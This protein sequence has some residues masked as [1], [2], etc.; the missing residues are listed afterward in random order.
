M[1]ESKTILGVLFDK[2][3]SFERLLSQMIAKGWP[4]FEECSMRL[5]VDGFFCSCSHFSDPC[6]NSSGAFVRCPFPNYGPQS[7][8]EM[9]LWRW[10]KGTLGCRYQRELKHHLVVAQCGW[11]LRSSIFSTARLC[12]VSPRNAIVRQTEPIPQEVY[13]FHFPQTDYFAQLQQSGR[14]QLQLTYSDILIGLGFSPSQ[15][16]VFSFKLEWELSDLPCSS[17]IWRNFRSWSLVR[18]T[19]RWPLQYR[20]K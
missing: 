16:H 13:A 12:P 19:G 3:L 8:S 17:V 6:P 2:N 9:L 1:V 7:D 15:L 4:L 5:N 18:I 11:D 14:D 20:V 10:G